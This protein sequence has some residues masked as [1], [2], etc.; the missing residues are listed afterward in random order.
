MSSIMESLIVDFPLFYI[1]LG[2]TVILGF[3]AICAGFFSFKDRLKGGLIGII[4]GIIT[5]IGLFIII[6]YI[7]MSLFPEFYEKMK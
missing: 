6:G 1:H 7:D 4:I 5:I 3:A 2:N